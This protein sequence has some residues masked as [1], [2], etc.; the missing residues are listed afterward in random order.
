MHKAHLS[1]GRRAGQPPRQ[2]GIGLVSLFRMGFA[3]IHI[4]QRRAVDDHIRLDFI[5]YSFYFARL[6]Q[7]SQDGGKRGLP[8]Y[9]DGTLAPQYVIERLG[10]R[11]ANVE[12]FAWQNDRSRPIAAARINFLLGR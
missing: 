12:A 11:L 2:E 5:Q 10:K 1:P 3:E 7:V 6:A 8:G 9:C 4:G